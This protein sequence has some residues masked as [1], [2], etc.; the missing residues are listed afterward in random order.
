MTQWFS[1]L[2]ARYFVYQ[3]NNN[4]KTNQSCIFNSITDLPLTY[5][6]IEENNYHATAH[7]YIYMDLLKKCNDLIDFNNFCVICLIQHNFKK[8]R[9]NIEKSNI[10]GKP[11]C[12]T[13]KGKQILW[14]HLYNAFH[15]DQHNHSLPLHEKLTMQH[16]EL[17]P[18]TKMRNSL[19]EDVLDSKMLFL[20]EVLILI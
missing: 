16:F 20:L 2:I 10:N 9:N 7:N 18:S 12:L 5:G 11:R 13:L 1:L 8:I 6:Q 14:R 15:W 19:A 4:L 17:D 3:L